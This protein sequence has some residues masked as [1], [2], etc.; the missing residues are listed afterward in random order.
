MDLAVDI[1]NSF[2]KAAF[3]DDGKLA[4]LET[5]SNFSVYQLEKFVSDTAVERAVLSSVKPNFESVEKY[6]DAHYRYVRFTHQTP[7]PFKN[8]YA[9]PQTLGKDRLAAVAGAFLLYP[10][11]HLLVIDAGTCITYDF[12]NKDDEYL[13][14][15]I[16]PGVRMRLKALHTFTGNLPLVEVE[17]IGYLIG[18]STKN[19]ILSGVI[20]GCIS[21]VDGIVDRYR[22]EFEELKVLITGGDSVFFESKLK[23]KIFAVPNLVLSGLVKI[24]DYNVQKG[25]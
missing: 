8:L 2:T 11:Q 22:S 3:F 23:N 1:G 5:F 13:G 12:L 14:G 24:L 18:S 17:N 6:L 21:E 25:K 19:S 10:H 15:A 9:T 20:N 7:L 4:H 16:S